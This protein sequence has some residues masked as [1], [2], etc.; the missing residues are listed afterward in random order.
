MESNSLR[1]DEVRNTLGGLTLAAVEPPGNR[2]NAVA[3]RAPREDMLAAAIAAVAILMFA[4][5]GIRV[6]PTAFYALIE[7]HGGANRFASTAFLLNVALVLFAWRRYKDAREERHKRALAEERAEIL[8]S[9]DQLT[10]LLILSSINETGNR[11]VEE[12]RSVGRQVAMLVINLD[13]FKNINDVYGHIAGDAVLRSVSDAIMGTIP[14]EALCARIGADEF[15]VIFPFCESARET[16]ADIAEHIVF[17]LREPV[18]IGG[19][20]VHGSA[21]IGISRTGKNCGEIEGLLRRANIAMHSAKDAGGDRATWFDT[22][23][24]SVLRARNEIE[25][26]LRRGIP[27]GEFVPHY[28]PQVDLLTGEFCGLEALARWNHPAGGIVGPD[29][30]IPVAEET[31]LIGDLFESV[32]EQAL[33]EARSWH[34][35]LILSVNVSPGQ[36]KDPWL[37]HRIL[38]IL[39]EVS[40]PPERLEVEITE[41][42]LFENLAVAQAI[43]ASLKNQGVRLALDDFGTGYSSLAHLRALPFDRIK[44]DRSF[45]QTMRKDPQSFAI[46]SA[47]TGMCRSLGVPVTAEGVEDGDIVDAL[48]MVGCDKAQGWHFGRPLCAEETRELLRTKGLDKRPLPAAADGLEAVSVADVGRAA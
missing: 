3:A 26:G 38:K 35:S 47:V 32:L 23:M 1:V 5:V 13:R 18:E 39:T 27:L 24:E 36:L 7:A 21:S 19:I 44:I 14:P 25:N 11:M 45:V 31:G 48:R 37:A 6:V 29:L 9:R 43:A 34:P 17:R 8:A 15:A 42:S 16:V 10:N 20:N 2:W 30:F 41:S 40:F 12:A 46:V 28:Q 22:S 33:Q 4:G